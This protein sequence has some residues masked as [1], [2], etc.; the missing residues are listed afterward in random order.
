M[1]LAERAEPSLAGPERTA[2]LALLEQEYADLLAAL[3]W[4]EAHDVRLAARLAGALIWFWYFSGRLA[5]WEHWIQSLVIRPEL[6]AADMQ[7]AEL[8]FGAGALARLRQDYAAALAP[9]EE[10][11][12][13]FRAAG[14]PRPLAH[15]LAHVGMVHTGR[16]DPRA[17]LPAYEDALAECRRS[18]DRWWEAFTLCYLGGA[19]AMAGD[20]T[21]A[22]DRLAESMATAEAVRDPWLRGVVLVGSAGVAA[23]QA[24]WSTARERYAQAAEQLRLCGD[25]NAF[26]HALLGW[27]EAAIQT[28]RVDEA[29]GALSEALARFRELGLRSG[30][31]R[32]LAGLARVAAERGE[33][34]RAARLSGAAPAPLPAVAVIVHAPDN[35]GYDRALSAARER[36]GE[37]AFAAERAAG[38]GLS[39]DAAIGYALEET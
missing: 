20:R 1:A 10:S 14:R 16:G 34:G 11:L 13:L 5:E 19:L 15:A 3:D 36:L 23:R 29:D 2:W 30:A 18:G 17:A 39:A 21:G 32:C 22:A 7:R 37:A 38:E 8:L 4:G 28:G 26:A 35:A 6:A 9:L 33:L 25:K 12:P 24:D 31:G 27:G